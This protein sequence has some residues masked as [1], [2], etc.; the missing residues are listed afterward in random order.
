M[1][2]EV[3][4]AFFRMGLMED[5]LAEGCSEE[6]LVVCEYSRIGLCALVKDGTEE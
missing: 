1:R 3:E 5:E 4:A 6:G 2:V